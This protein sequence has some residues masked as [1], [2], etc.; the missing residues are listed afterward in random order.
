M[1]KFVIYCIA[2]D[3]LLLEGNDPFIGTEK[4]AK[5]VLKHEV[6]DSKR[7]E[8]KPLK[9]IKEWAKKIKKQEKAEGTIGYR[10]SP[11]APEF[12]YKPEERHARYLLILGEEGVRKSGKLVKDFASVEEAVIMGSRSIKQVVKQFP[13]YAYFILDTER[14]GYVSRLDEKGITDY[15]RIELGNS[16]RKSRT[17]SNA[18]AGSGK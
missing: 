8:I 17:A 4:E 2:S 18:R 6:V 15:E 11:I 1:E 7:Y 16:K 12:H 5:H 3:Q 10:F 13:S 14:Y 9:F